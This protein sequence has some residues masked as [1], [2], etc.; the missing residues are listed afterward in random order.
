MNPQDFANLQKKLNQLLTEDEQLDEL[1]PEVYRIAAKK[2]FQQYEE[3]SD[4]ITT[5]IEQINM[6]SDPSNPVVVELRKTLEKYRAAARKSFDQTGKLHAHAGKQAVKQ[7]PL[8][9]SVNP[10]GSLGRM[11]K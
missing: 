4:A 2:R 5:F 10:K 7:Q 11:L 8:P 9:P 1:S 3:L 6:I